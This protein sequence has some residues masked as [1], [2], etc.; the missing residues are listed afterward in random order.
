MKT[1]LF[2][3]AA[4]CL[5]LALIFWGE[6]AGPAAPSR[7]LVSDITFNSADAD[8]AAAMPRVLKAHLRGVTRIDIRL[9]AKIHDDHYDNLF[10][11]ADGPRAIRL[12][13]THPRT[14]NLA[15]SDKYYFKITEQ[16]ALNQ[17][18]DIRLS[19]AK[20]ELIE[21]TVDGK[22][23]LSLRNPG[24]TAFP[25][26]VG[27]VAI[28]TGY[29]R[30]R[31]LQGEIREVVLAV[32]HV[33]WGSV[34]EVVAL[35]ISIGLSL[36]AFALLLR[37]MLIRRRCSV[38]TE[39]Q[40]GLTLLGIVVIAV[41]LGWLVGRA[42]PRFAKWYPLAIV[43]L[44]M[45]LFPSLARFDHLTAA[46]RWRLLA[47]A[48]Q[49]IGVI[50]LTYL[51]FATGIVIWSQ[52]SLAMIGVILFA[53]LTTVVLCF[54]SLDAKGLPARIVQSFC[55]VSLTIAAWMSLVELP[56]WR[57]L[58]ESLWH[59]SV[60]VFATVLSLAISWQFIFAT[61]AEPPR[62]APRAGALNKSLAFLEGIAIY[63]TFLLLSFR[64][65][66]FFLGWSEYHWEYYVGAIRNLREGSWLLWD[67]PS[68]Y[69]FLN[70]LIPA[71]L[72]ASNSWQALYV[73]QG[74]L[75]LIA[76]SLAYRA[77]V[78]VAPGSR[79]FAFLLVVAGVFFADPDLIGP[80]LYPS[81]SVMRFFWCYVLL[82]VLSRF[83]AKD[84]ASVWRDFMLPG[85]GAWLAGVLWS[86]ESAIY[87]TAIYFLALAAAGLL[88]TPALG[89]A[90]AI[91]IVDFVRTFVARSLLPAGCLAGILAAV[92][93]YYQLKLGHSPDWRMYFEHALGYAGGFEAIPVSSHGAGWVFVLAFVAIASTIY[94]G[95][96]QTGEAQRALV[97]QAGALGCIL[98]ISS[99]F[100]G[101]AAPSNVTAVLPIIALTLAI[102]LKA[103]QS[104]QGPSRSFLAA[105]AVPIYVVLLSM[106]LGAS[107]FPRTLRGI[108]S[109]TGQ[110]EQRLRVPEPP[111]KELLA[112]AGVTPSDRVVYYGFAAA[113]PAYEDPQ[114]G[115]GV[116]DKSWLPNPLQL[117]EE[118]ITSERRRIV[119]SRFVERL[120]ESGFFVQAKGQHEERAREWISIIGATHR[121]AQVYENRE[122]RIIRFLK[123]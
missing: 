34:P 48:L 117:L 27:L 65:D 2:A 63:A 20:N 55:L 56:N 7:F 115:R 3:V 9:T 49:L 111:L 53:G 62:T 44:T 1:L 10:Q 18:H 89:T 112:K 12:E 45:P 113:M 24:L 51:L 83:V 68:Q 74:S 77:I 40:A 100:V 91:G 37:D 16:F 39:V 86:F 19:V 29:S 69:G 28:G 61:N 71:M 21:L 109:L 13:V 42:E 64:W 47:G 57:N 103:G 106:S 59:P 101:R 17:W 33:A 23:L 66:A 95:P 116:Y 92:W 67:T 110:I 58:N 79:L 70:I 93:A 35:V 121:T 105:T 54:S 122:Y 30:T 41:T 90:R 85:L 6:V 75:L 104:P 107:A 36:I 114:G 80:S 76:S 118:P 119:V 73:F 43:G 38:A 25:Y 4:E 15:L 60:A 22:K 108:E 78:M 72:P 96:L 84:G 31:P 88:P 123:N 120:P 81:S 97:C 87:C 5:V 8:P 32:D 46:T 102:C 11:T 98:A 52:L 99:Y 26:D 82:F 14:L 50:G 94:R